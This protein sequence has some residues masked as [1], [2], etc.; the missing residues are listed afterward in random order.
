MVIDAQTGSATSTGKLLRTWRHRRRRSQLDVALG[1]EISAKHLSFL[2]TDRAQPSRLMIERLSDELD[3]PLRS[4]NALF[5]AA[6]FAPRH[7]ERDVADLGAALSAME[8]V[9]VGLE[10]NP[11]LA[12]D[13]VWDLVSANR[14]A[15]PFFS[16]VS[17]ELT[18]PP[19]N[20]LRATLHP[21]GLA[22]RILNLGQWRTHTLN[23]VARQ[24]DRT[25]DPELA[26]LLEE[27]SS[28]PGEAGR[29]DDSLAPNELA[30][31]LRMAFEQG[32]RRSELAFIYTTTVFGS[33]RDV[34]L[35][36][37][38][39]EAFFPADEATAEALRSGVG[40]GA[41]PAV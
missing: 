1:A 24:W 35:E 3:I 18:E 16:G 38:A 9:L 26:R 11:A 22:P 25:G 29:D 36:E 37:I 13:A 5:L 7:P 31:P 28:Y 30:V 8:A 4:R 23:R 33:P 14:A 10:P 34:T 17:A 39:I 6:G 2:E 12:V 15:A 20:V 41:E 32:G 40:S 27:L 19:V 21:K